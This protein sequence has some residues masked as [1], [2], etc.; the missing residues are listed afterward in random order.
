YKEDIRPFDEDFAKI[1]AV[2]PKVYRMREGYG[3]P[4]FENF[5]YIAEDLDEAGLE[6]LVIYDGEG[7]PDGVRYKK[8]VLYVNE[9]VKAHHK[10]IEELQAEIAVL[11][12]VVCSHHPT[13][14]V[15]NESHTA[16][17]R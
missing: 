7:R 11:K 12:R 8:V 16:R 5:G 17:A 3:P 14:V 15:C 4:G 9:V 6:S 2:E 13:E 10:M 1:L